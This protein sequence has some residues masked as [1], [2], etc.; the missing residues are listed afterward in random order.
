MFF[1][2]RYN[3]IT[4]GTSWRKRYQL[5]NAMVWEEVLAIGGC[6]LGVGIRTLQ[7]AISNSSFIRM[8]FT[9]QNKF[10]IN[11]SCTCRYQPLTP[12]SGKP[13]ASCNAPK[14]RANLVNRPVLEVLASSFLAANGHLWYWNCCVFFWFQILRHDSACRLDILLF[15]LYKIRDSIWSPWPIG[16]TVI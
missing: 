12:A 5:E 7:L 3:R 11:Q 9:Y 16:D 4:G 10:V 2:I 13:Q 14:S 1:L 6:P 15:C 8:H